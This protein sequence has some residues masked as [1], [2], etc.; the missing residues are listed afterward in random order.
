MVGGSAVLGELEPDIYE[1]LL[2]N[3]IREIERVMKG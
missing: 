3:V 2:A 1:T